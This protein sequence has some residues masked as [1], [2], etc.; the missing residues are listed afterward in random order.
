[1]SAQ[2]ERN[3]GLAVELLRRIGQSDKLGTKVL[4]QGILNRFATFEDLMVGLSSAVVA[5][6]PE[7][8]QDLGLVLGTDL[9]LLA[10]KV[11]EAKAELDARPKLDARPEFGDHLLAKNCI[12]IIAGAERGR[13]IP[14]ETP[15]TALRPVGFLRKGD[16]DWIRGTLVQERAFDE[17]G[18]CFAP[19]GRDLLWRVLNNQ[20]GEGDVFLATLDK[21]KCYAFAGDRDLL[22][23]N[24]NAVL[25]YLCCDGGWWRWRCY[26]FSH[27][28]WNAAIKLL[29][30]GNSPS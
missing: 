5:D 7:L 20:E 10:A 18:P 30:L 25:L 3:F 8:M 21:T 16:G 11:A 22:H 29:T 15:L 4:Q 13:N 26:C 9:D 12:S 17:S 6:Y 23:S 14:A 24:G 28:R 2:S 27:G 19:W 1:M